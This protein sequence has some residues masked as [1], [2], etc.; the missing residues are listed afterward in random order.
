MLLR[1][2][3]KSACA[4]CYSTSASANVLNL[5][6]NHNANASTSAEVLPNL[7][8]LN[9]NGALRTDVREECRWTKELYSRNVINEVKF[10]ARRNKHG[11]VGKTEFTKVKT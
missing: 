8:F 10:A 6:L 9:T 3:T 7:G 4:A 2:S 1:Q 11:V 5:N